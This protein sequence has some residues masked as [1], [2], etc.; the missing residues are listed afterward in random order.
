MTLRSVSGVS[1]TRITRPI[2]V[3]KNLNS[4]D[5]TIHILT[6]FLKACRITR[7]HTFKK[8]C[9][10]PKACIFPELLLNRKGQTTNFV[11]HDD[12]IVI[13]NRHGKFQILYM[14]SCSQNILQSQTLPVSGHSSYPHLTVC[15]V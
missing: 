6:S 10:I 15:N 9:K 12:E 11:T 8:S 5:N 3:P 1:A 13:T 2:Y 4:H 14:F 7:E